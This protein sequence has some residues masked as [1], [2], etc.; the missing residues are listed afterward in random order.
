MGVPPD[1]KSEIISQNGMPDWVWGSG[2]THSYPEGFYGS[3]S[4]YGGTVALGQ[5]AKIIP[6]KDGKLVKQDLKDTSFWPRGTQHLSLAMR[7]FVIMAPR[8]IWFADGS[9]RLPS[10]GKL[11]SSA[12]Q[13]FFGNNND[14]GDTKKLVEWI[15]AEAEKHPEFWKGENGQFIKTA[16]SET[17]QSIK[18]N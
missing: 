12:N 11:I 4:C 14:R 6:Y 17:I 9:G 18:N 10:Q 15:K 3:V 1:V 8:Q 7:P 2:K 13:H 5:G 16:V